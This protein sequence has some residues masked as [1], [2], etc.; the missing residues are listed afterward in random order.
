MYRRN[1]YELTMSYDKGVEGEEKMWC[2]LFRDGT[3]LSDVLLNEVMLLMP[4]SGEFGCPSFSFFA[5]VEF[6]NEKCHAVVVGAVQSKI[7]SDV[8]G[9]GM[10]GGKLRSRGRGY[11]SPPAEFVLSPCHPEP[12]GNCTQQLD[13]V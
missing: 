9:L 3:S 10:R 8:F 13:L 11:G 7:T 12:M 1:C 4:A 5:R 2:R 6:C